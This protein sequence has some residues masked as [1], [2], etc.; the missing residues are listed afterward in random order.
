MPALIQTHTTS[1]G[2]PWMRG[3]DTAAMTT[4]TTPAQRRLF[5][6]LT[7]ARWAATGWMCVQLIIAATA[8]PGSIDELAEPAVAW[9]LFG[10]AVAVSAA[11]TLVT[12][13]NP[14]RL[15]SPAFTGID[16]TVAYSLYCADGI[17]FPDGHVF[18]SQLT[19]ASSWT[20]VALLTTAVAH[21]PRVGL[22]AGAT[23]PTGRIA[24][25]VL[26][27]VDIDS[28]HRV[29]SFA[30]SCTF[31]A[32]AGAILGMIAVQLS[33]I[34]AENA[35]HRARRELERRLHDNVL[36]TLAFVARRT[37]QADPQLAAAVRAADTEVR[38]WLRTG[39]PTPGDDLTAI[40]AE[41]TAAGSRAGVRVTVAEIVDPDCR[42]PADVIAALAAAAGE[43]V[44]NV[45][46]HSGVDNCHVLVDADSGTITV[47]IRD[48]GRGFDHNPASERIGW[49]NSI[50]GRIADIDGTATI[51]TA[52][53]QGTEVTLQWQ[54]RP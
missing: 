6:G 30:S 40:G 23:L 17:V 26:S 45:G 12:F 29:V 46:K 21:G 28:L 37:E 32:A 53:G 13:K 14:D 31:Y 8:A 49:Q 33:T 35:E 48:H 3:D 51:D 24:G 5:V 10:V 38:A 47:T 44:T 18:A 43:A 9:A 41:A 25:A 54:A 52:P 16:L 36:Q 15:R 39:S 19:L 1:G 22:A 27:D 50:R 4:A 7:A 20:L 2:D 34:E 42:P 11:A